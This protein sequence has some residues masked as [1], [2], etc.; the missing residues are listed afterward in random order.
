MQ[1]RSFAALPDQV[2]DLFLGDTLVP[3]ARAFRDARFTR[4]KDTDGRQTI[5]V[6]IGQTFQ[7]YTYSTALHRWF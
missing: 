2:R 7:T 1:S 4:G 5:T 6:Q 3:A